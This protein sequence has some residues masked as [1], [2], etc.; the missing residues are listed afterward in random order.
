MSLAL[1]GLRAVLVWMERERL[2]YIARMRKRLYDI[3]RN[4]F[5][6]FNALGFGDMYPQLP[7]HSLL[8]L[9]TPGWLEKRWQWEEEYRITEAEWA[10]L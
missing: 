7:A 9:N 4:M 6:W 2:L 8:Q 3:N 1:D 10:N 5:R